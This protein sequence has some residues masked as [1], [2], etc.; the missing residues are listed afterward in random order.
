MKELLLSVKQELENCNH[1]TL[2]NVCKLPTYKYNR[3]TLQCNHIYHIDCIKVTKNTKLIKCHYC[4]KKTK[5]IS[6][7]CN[8]EN[9]NKFTINDSNY[10]NIH[11]RKIKININKFSDKQIIEINNK[12]DSLILL[13][14]TPNTS[15]ICNF[16]MKNNN[17]CTNKL[18]N[19]NNLCGIHKK[20]LL[21][22]INKLEL[23]LNNLDLNKNEI[24]NLK[25]EIY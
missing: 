22:D 15:N 5:I 7:K 17:I 18:K 9:C 1:D 16:C 8:H 25:T 21:N 24:N 12:L 14:D 6:K 11:I 23:K 2:C 19:N 4:Q 3:I 10:C 20:K 13:R